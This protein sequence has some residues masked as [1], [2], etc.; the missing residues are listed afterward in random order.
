MTDTQRNCC[1]PNTRSDWG[2]VMP[3]MGHHASDQSAEVQRATRLRYGIQVWNGTVAAV[4]VEVETARAVAE[5]D[6]KGAESWR[7]GQRAW[8]LWQTWT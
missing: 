2:E 7:L 1:V 6:S 3:D 5:V 8:S 4:R